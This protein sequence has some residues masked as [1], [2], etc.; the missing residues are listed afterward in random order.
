MTAAPIHAGEATHVWHW[1][2]KLFERKG[3]PCHILARGRM[4][5]ILVE[6]VDGY[7]VVTSRWAVREPDH[8]Q[9]R[10]SRATDGEP[11]LLALDP[12]P[13]VERRARAKLDLP[14]QP[15]AKIIRAD[16]VPAGEPL[17]PSQPA[18]AAPTVDFHRGPN[19]TE[20]VAGKSI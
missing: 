6:F 17:E 15:T 18:A 1:R 9:G 16:T 8:D 2:S 11:I 19:P 12:L 7:R 3:Q 5:S 20:F 4:N 13:D 10:L 14:P